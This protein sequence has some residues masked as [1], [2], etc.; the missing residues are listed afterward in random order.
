MGGGWVSAAWQLVH[1]Q[2]A[3]MRQRDLA[4]VGRRAAADEARH[5]DRM[6]RRAEGPLRHQR[7]TG[8]Q[9]P[10][11]RPDRGDFQHLV[12]R[13]RRQDC[14]KAPRQH[15]LASARRADEQ[16]VVPNYEPMNYVLI[17]TPEN[18]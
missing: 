8:G 4:R 2:H 7:A 10:R 17:V 5:R 13:R 1:E 14:R 3:A 18:E 16:H 9:E 12:A 15:R 11:H 6:V